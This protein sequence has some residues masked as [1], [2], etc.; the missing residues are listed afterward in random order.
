MATPVTIRIQN[1]KPTPTRVEDVVVQIYTT[2]GV[3]V[4]QGTSDEA[5]EVDLLLGDGSYDV[6]FYKI[7]FIPGLRQP[8]RIVVDHTLSN[9]FLM[10]GHER[11]V[12]E[13][14][15]PRLCRVS[16]SLYAGDGRVAKD[17]RLAF[18]LDIDLLVADGRAVPPE[19]RVSKSPDLNGLF[20][21]DL[22]RG[23]DYKCFLDYSD[24]SFGSAST[25]LNVCVPDWGSIDLAI[26]LFPMLVNVTFSELTKELHVGDD[27]SET[28]RTEAIYSDGSTRSETPPWVTYQVVCDNEDVVE[29]WL[30]TGFIGLRALAPGVANVTVERSIGSN[31]SWLS[32]P[33]FTSDILV[34][35]VS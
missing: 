13:S 16:G 15:D 33:E 27:V 2:A 24:Q 30:G 14:A 7:G 35:T 4:T 23:V 12:P 28:T 26:L 32:P 6:L 11:E 21:F 25:P 17:I 29:A 5:G 1:D 31:T 34:V 18:A 10:T 20:E 8:Y 22:F 9:I 3:F 19:A